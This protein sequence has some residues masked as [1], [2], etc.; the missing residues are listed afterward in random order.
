MQQYEL[1]YIISGDI[2][3]SD[4]ENKAKEVAK[5]VESCGGKIVEENV[6][7]RKSLS[8]PIKKQ[9]SGVYIQLFFNI[10]PGKNSKLVIELGSYPFVLRHFLSHAF[11]PKPKVI[12]KP[13]TKEKVSSVTKTDGKT[14]EKQ[15]HEAEVVPEK[16]EVKAKKTPTKV[17]EDKKIKEKKKK[18]EDIRKPAEKEKKPTKEQEIVREIEGEEKRLKKLDEKIDELLKE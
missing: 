10:D 8:Y 11:T 2:S 5:M 4:T 12:L 13:K 17:T 15:K 9:T 3:E 1:N 7:G 18:P 16:K 6:I 14:E